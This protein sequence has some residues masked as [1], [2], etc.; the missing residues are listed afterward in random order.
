MN[1]ET[2][3]TLSRA[4]AHDT[5]P[6]ELREA[7]A[8]FLMTGSMPVDPIDR[9]YSKSIPNLKP[10]H[11]VTFWAWECANQT[12]P[13]GRDL[14]R[15]ITVLQVVMDGPEVLGKALATEN[16]DVQDMLDALLLA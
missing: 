11:T 10:W 6:E 13:L 12:N 8:A 9:L 4:C 7:F 3:H 16:P 5:I 2:R 15:L 1:P 14:D